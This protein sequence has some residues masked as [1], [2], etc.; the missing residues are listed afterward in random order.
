MRLIA[1]HFILFFL[2]IIPGGLFAQDTSSSIKWEV[3][4]KKVAENTYELQFT[5][6]GAAGW[7]LYAP[8]QLLNDVPTTEF[9]FGDSLIQLSGAIKD[10]GLAKTIRS[11]IFNVP[12]KI[13]EGATKWKQLIKISGTVPAKLQGTLAFTSDAVMNSIR[14]HLII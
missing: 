6:A 5:S 1:R 4:N 3:S 14:L 10:S 12:V 11:S 8:N 2:F 9:S 13:Y 7:Q